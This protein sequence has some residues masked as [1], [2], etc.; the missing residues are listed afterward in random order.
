MYKGIYLKYI[1]E[2]ENIIPDVVSYGIKKGKFITNEHTLTNYALNNYY[3]KQYCFVPY[4]KEHYMMIWDF[5]Y[6]MNKPEVE[7]ILKDFI[8]NL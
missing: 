1:K 3:N 2:E 7:K 4:K 6:K 5:D 8:N